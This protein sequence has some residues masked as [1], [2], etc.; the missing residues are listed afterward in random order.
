LKKLLVLI[1]ILCIYST[2]NSQETKINQI[3]GI[4]QEKE[5]SHIQF[6]KFKKFDIDLNKVA[7]KSISKIAV[8]ENRVYIL[9][10][11]LSRIYVFDKRARYLHSIGRPGQGPGDL[12]YPKDF[13]ISEDGKIYIV[14]STVK[15]VEVFALD[16]NFLERIELKIPE[17]IYYSKPTNILVTSDK[18]FIIGYNLS[19]HLLDVYDSEGKFITNILKRKDPVFVPGVN[20]ANSSQISFVDQENSILHFNNLT[21]VFTSVKLYGEIMQSFSAFNRLHQDEVK[22]LQETYKEKSRKL[23]VREGGANYFA[24]WSNF[25]VDKKGYIYVFLV[26]KKKEEKQKLF[27]FSPDGTFL[28]WTTIPY[29]KDIPRVDQIYFFS[30]EFIFVTYNWDIYFAKRK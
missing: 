22:K 29:F 23:M 30:D 27:V 8:H 11:Q 24:M 4:L 20:L 7:F 21:G 26:W 14:C 19:P 17:D 5:R 2:L 12:Q 16:G 15:R 28:Y 6:I 18:K 25:C 10:H 3:R 13:V 9:D 1:F